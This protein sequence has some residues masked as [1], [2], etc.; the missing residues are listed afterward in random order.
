MTDFHGDQAKI[1]KKKKSFSKY[2]NSQIFFVK[3]S[4]IGPWVSRIDWCE[5]HCTGPVIISQFFKTFSQLFKTIYRYKV[6]VWKNWEISE[7]LLSQIRL[8]LT[9]FSA[10]N[11]L[12]T[13]KFLAMRNILLYSVGNLSCVSVWMNTMEIFSVMRVLIFDKIVHDFI[14]ND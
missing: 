11:G 9:C 14:G 5:G 10:L 7:V 4:R 12:V 2:P 6:K 1:L 13:S 8:A 3:I